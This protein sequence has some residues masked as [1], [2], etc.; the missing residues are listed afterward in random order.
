MWRYRQYTL[1]VECCNEAKLEIERQEEKK[2]K[3]N[4]ESKIC[5]TIR[6]LATASASAYAAVAVFRVQMCLRLWV[7]AFVMLR[8]PRNK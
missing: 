4:T 6:A 8:A 1:D 5:T 3:I 2:K 7:V